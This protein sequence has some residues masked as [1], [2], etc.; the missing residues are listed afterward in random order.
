MTKLNH[1][2]YIYLEYYDRNLM[3]VLESLPALK[4]IDTRRDTYTRD[5]DKSFKKKGKQNLNF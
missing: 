3:D 1:L 5:I 2:E 4:Y